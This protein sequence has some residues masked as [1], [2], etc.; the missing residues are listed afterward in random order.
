MLTI[1]VLGKGC[2]KCKVTYNQVQKALLEIG[3][4]ATVIKVEDMDEILS[5]NVMSTPGLLINENIKCVG[6]IPNT[7]EII[8]WIKEVNHE[9]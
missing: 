2:S 4:E 8:Q 9:H 1:K 7:K 3:I 6:R 5:Y